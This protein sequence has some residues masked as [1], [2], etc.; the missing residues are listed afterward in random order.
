MPLTSSASLR[1]HV[2]CLCDTRPEIKPRDEWATVGYTHIWVGRDTAFTV[3][4]NPLFTDKFICTTR[5]CEIR[6]FYTVRKVMLYLT[7]RWVRVMRTVRRLVKK[8]PRLLQ[9]FRQIPDTSPS[10]YFSGQVFSCVS[11]RFQKIRA[12]QQLCH[13][14]G[15]SRSEQFEQQHEFPYFLFFSFFH[16]Y[17][18]TV[19]LI[20]GHDAASLWRRL[21]TF[22][23][24]TVVPRP[25][26]WC[27]IWFVW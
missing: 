2:Y 9:Q 14:T 27:E 11:F 3:N 24:K 18:S 1:P 23:D 21:P 13:R 4:T 19:A 20:E 12:Q 7:A 22:R 15:L 16:N 6:V 8:P 17:A 5:V 25:I 26:R 10:T